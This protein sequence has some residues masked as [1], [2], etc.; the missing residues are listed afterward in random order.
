VVLIRETPASEAAVST[1]DYSD[2]LSYLLVVI[3]LAKPEPEQVE[4]YNGIGTKMQKG[5]R[6]VLRE[7]QELSR[8]E[9]L[10]MLPA[11]DGLSQAIEI[12]GSGIHQLLATGDGGKVVGVLSQLRV[13]RFFWNEGV[14]FPSIDRLYPVILRD[15]SST[16][17]HQTV[18]SIK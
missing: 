14:N 3:G 10:I 2:L 16:L 1:F 4:M 6:I 17:G 15:L 13:M 12:L 8:K 7:I 5:E 18:I 9:S 11:E